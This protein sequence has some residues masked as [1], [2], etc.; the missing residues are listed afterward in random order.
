MMIIIINVPQVAND[1][2]NK[3]SQQVVN[4]DNENNNQ[5][6]DSENKNQFIKEN[7]TEKSENKNK[8]GCSLY[9]NNDNDNLIIS[10]TKEETPSFFDW[11]F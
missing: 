5:I 1:E 2:I 6:F 11:T 10:E 9:L 3:I 7:C 8:E 4:E